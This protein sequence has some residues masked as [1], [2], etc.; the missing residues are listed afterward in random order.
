MGLEVRRSREMEEGIPSPTE[1]ALPDVGKGRRG[2][3]SSV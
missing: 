2:R 1:G 3:E